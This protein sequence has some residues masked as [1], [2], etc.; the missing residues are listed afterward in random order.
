MSGKGSKKYKDLGARTLGKHRI[1]QRYL[2][3]T[4]IDH[5]VLNHSAWKS[6]ISYN[7]KKIN[8]VSISQK[9]SYKGNMMHFMSNL[10][11]ISGL[12][13]QFLAIINPEQY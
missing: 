4:R 8:C 5:Y 6:I 9:F 12:A 1:L 11:E 7:Y 2:R 13:L 10:A 3:S